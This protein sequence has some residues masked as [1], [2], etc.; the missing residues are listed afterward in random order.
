MFKTY[1]RLK[2]VWNVQ[3][4]VTAVWCF[5]RME[6]PIVQ[7]YTYSPKFL[8]WLHVFLTLLI[9][10]ICACVRLTLHS[11]STCLSHPDLLQHPPLDVVGQILVGLKGHHAV[12]IRAACAVYR[13]PV[14]PKRNQTRLQEK[15]MKESM[16]A[17]FQH[18]MRIYVLAYQR[19]QRVRTSDEFSQIFAQAR[20][21]R[22][23]PKSNNN[24]GYNIVL[25]NWMPI[26]FEQH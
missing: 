9:P 8:D 21:Q 6:I 7:N 10:H 13:A 3:F 2:Y 12:G 14:R 15:M 26:S 17:L 4:F 25:L 18:N 19:K 24:S 5:R 22:R 11:E 23:L 16:V 1:S 20:T